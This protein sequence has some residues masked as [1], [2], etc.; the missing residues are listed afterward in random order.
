MVVIQ[1]Y[2][3]SAPYGRNWRYLFSN[4]HASTWSIWVVVIIFF[5]L[6]WGGLLTFL[7]RLTRQHS[8]LLPIFAISLGAPRWCQMLWGT[9]S[10]GL[11]IPWGGQA[12]GAVLGRCL[13]SWLGVLDAI[14]GV[15]FGMILLQTLTR[16]HI[17]FTLIAAQVIGSAA[18]IAARASAPNNIGPGDVF[19]DF[20]FGWREPLGLHWFWVGLLLQLVICVGF[21]AFF[22]KE[23]LSKP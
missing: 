4:A 5:I 3:L 1:N 6:I 13:W 10:I 14:Q 12:F 20:S 19:P 16:V 7:A 18:T 2:W 21:F 15:G 11:Y 9:S 8:W 17:A 22:R 23:Q